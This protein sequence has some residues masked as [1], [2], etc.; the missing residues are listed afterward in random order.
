MTKLYLNL[1]GNLY[2][3]YISNQRD[4]IVHYGYYVKMI[5]SSIRIEENKKTPWK[6]GL[7]EFGLSD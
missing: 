1:S 4:I 2:P 3:D 7:L 6:R 5:K